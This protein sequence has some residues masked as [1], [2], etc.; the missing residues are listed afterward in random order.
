MNRTIR[1]AT[2]LFFLSG[3]TGL[4]YEV[5]WT[6]RLSLTFGHTVLAV[7]TVLTAY[8]AG[9]ALGSLLG[10]R[11]ADRE[12]SRPSTHASRFLIAYG[13]LEAMVGLWALLSL[14][15][16]GLVER[17]YLALATGGLQGL[18][19]H[20]VAFAGS[21]LVLV[22]PTIAMGATLPV[23]S[24]LLVHHREDLGRFL[25]RLYGANTLGAFVG[26]AASGFLLLP[27]L[28][29][30]A[31]LLLT[32]GLNLGLAVVAWRLGRS[33]GLQEARPTPPAPL[34]EEGPEGRSPSR[35]GAWIVPLAFGVAGVASMGYQVGWTR[36]LV[37]VFGSSAY[38]FSAILATFLAGLGLG[39]LLYPRVLGQRSPRLVH[40]ALLQLL[41]G[42]AAAATIP[43]LEWFP[44]LYLGVHPYLGGSF[45]L[46]LGGQFAFWSL[47][48]LVPTFVMGLVFPLATQLHAR[49]LEILGRGVGEVYS[50]NTVGCIAGSFLAGFVAVPFLGAQWTLK[51]SC[52]VSLAVAAWLFA[53]AGGPRRQRVGGLAVTAA[54]VV[55]VVLLPR[56]DPGMMSAGFAV[57][58]PRLAGSPLDPNLRLTRPPAFYRDGLSCTVS[59]HI[60]DSRS[61]H[62][63]VNGKTDASL[64][65]GDL[66]TQYLAGILP[67]LVHG[68]PRT[69]A[70]V[71]LGSG[72][73][74]TGLASIPGVQRIDCAEL[75]PAVVEAGRY[76]KGYN[77]SILDDPRVRMHITD[78][79]TF[80]LSSP[81]RYDVVI[82]EPSNPWIAGIGNLFTRDFYEG[83]QA[84]LQPGGIMAQW[85]QLYSLSSREIGLILKSFYEVF[86]HG[87]AWR[88]S[89]GDMLLLGSRQRLSLDLAR[90]RRTWHASTAMQEI[91]DRLG[92]SDPDQLAGH[93]LWPREQALR[94]FPSDVLNTDDRPL[95]EFLAPLNLY[96]ANRENPRVVAALDATGLPPGVPPTPRH[97]AQAAVAWL[98]LDR[99]GA[100]RRLLQEQPELPGREALQAR[101]ALGTDS[102][103]ALAAMATAL[104][105]RP[106]DSALSGLHA[107]KLAE[108]GEWEEAIRSYLQALR[109]PTPGSRARLRTELGI[110]LREAGRPGEAVPVLEAALGE[111]L[112][113]APWT[114]LGLAQAAL[115]R[116]EEAASAFREA[117]RRNP[118]DVEA[119][120]GL[121][122]ALEAQGD[123]PGA[124]DA[125]REALGLVPDHVEGMVRLGLAEG[126]AG[127]HVLARRTLNQALRLEP[128]NPRALRALDLLE[129]D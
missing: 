110:A 102:P 88:T 113:S 80:L 32:A 17:G 7:S 24:R 124:A 100:V 40:L 9:L 27:A 14:P 105:A 31:S 42:L 98:Y 15:L 54:A 1:A 72:L 64:I 6:R 52:L 11:W 104:Q 55:A 66:R 112:D 44:V 50:A 73:T 128:Q 18:P 96:R 21:M 126:R 8:M 20:L 111:T 83:C 76:W 91:L 56:W 86:P 119:F 43:V 16:L 118:S 39:G 79:R 84:R 60:R 38:A 114:E 95:L 77:G 47:L 49:S 30:K 67:A 46:V 26:A 106:A 29:L 93:F 70:V 116:W 34:R 127:Q 90:A 81:E 3:A 125:F 4:V 123:S 117:G 122:T 57:S 129:R 59:V 87:M 78:G 65:P 53:A 2:L 75:E 89:T 58:P 121:G 19:L 33:G 97:L 107:K 120:M 69:A 37:L 23:M 85:V 115:E 99:P 109:A 62:L 48:L 108:D 94:L 5:L 22:P 12:A 82:S 41:V 36:A 71:G 63:R 35:V 92:L 101:L 103:E 61:V 51:L 10:G 68:S 74:L 25:S 28:G 13:V 45:W